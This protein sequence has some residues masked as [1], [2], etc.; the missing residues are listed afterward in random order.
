[1]LASTGHLEVHIDQISRLGDSPVQHIDLLARRN[2]CCVDVDI[3]NADV[4]V[5]RAGLAIVVPI[6]YYGASRHRARSFE[7]R[8]IDGVSDDLCVDQ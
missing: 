8:K 4:E 1:M 2:G 7:R 6:D 3:P 5:V